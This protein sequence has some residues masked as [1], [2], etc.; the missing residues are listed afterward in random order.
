MNNF[1]KKSGNLDVS[2]W[3]T[4]RLINHNAPSP[5]VS[6]SEMEARQEVYE[7]AFREGYEHG[8]ELGLQ[9]AE[10]Q[11]RLIEELLAALRKPFDEQSRQ[12]TEVLVQ[13]A[14]RIARA[15]VARELESSP[16]TLLS[17]VQQSLSLLE[18]SEQDVFIHLNPH[19][20]QTLRSLIS[21]REVARNWQIVDDPHVSLEDFRIRCQD[22][23]VDADLDARIRLVVNQVLDQ[24]PDTKEV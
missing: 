21:D 18:N 14:G 2:A 11:L 7:Q 1:S 17:M 20:A 3:E 5:A 19:T 6:S 13:L 9:E 24:K 23:I 12:L 10:D 4:P 16:E 22:S 15:I 8:K